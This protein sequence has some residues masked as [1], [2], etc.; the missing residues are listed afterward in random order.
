LEKI[1]NPSPVAPLTHEIKS[2]SQPHH[3]LIDTRGDDEAIFETT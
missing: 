1:P 3:I 2:S